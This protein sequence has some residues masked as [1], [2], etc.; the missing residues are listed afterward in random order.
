MTANPSAYPAP[1]ARLLSIAVSVSRAA[2][3]RVSS[4]LLHRP[5]DSRDS[6][7]L[8]LLW[9]AGDA[10]VKL[11]SVTARPYVRRAVGNVITV[12]EELAAF[13]PEYVEVQHF[14]PAAIARRMGLGDGAISYSMWSATSASVQRLDEIRNRAKVRF[15]ELASLFEIHADPL[16][17]ILSVGRRVADCVLTPTPAAK[18]AAWAD[19]LESGDA[20]AG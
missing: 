20:A 19:K 6:T 10:V 2:R 18:V 12:V 16:A 9:G 13:A 14:V 7:S 17:R 4:D 1:V 15:V 5:D 3:N 8:I 11:A